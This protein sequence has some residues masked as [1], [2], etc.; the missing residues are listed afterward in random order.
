MLKTVFFDWFETIARYEPPRHELYKQVFQQVNIDLPARAIVRGLLAADRYL[1]EENVKCPLHQRS[2]E[3]QMAVYLRYPEEI[4]KAAGITIPRDVQ[5]KVI[6]KALKLSKSFIFVLFDDV[7]ITMELLKNSGLK[8][9]LLTNATKESLS[10]TG[11]LGLTPY[12]D[13]IVNSEEAGALKPDPVIFRA[14]LKRAGAKPEEAMHVGDQY[15]LDIVGAKGVGI[16]PVL[17][18]R[19]DAYPEITDCTRIR[20]L[21]ELG[22]LI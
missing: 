18:D 10:V 19:E 6:Q 11:K 20:T 2:V 1:F 21:T 4:G 14:A 3:E 7:L 5:I 9:G 13:F 16:T 17:I 8:I 22:K 12:L 15:E